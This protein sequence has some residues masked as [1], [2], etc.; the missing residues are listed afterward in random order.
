MAV[1]M[2]Q[3]T[4][5]AR[6]SPPRRE[7]Q[8][9]V[10]DAFSRDLQKSFAER[11]AVAPA[12]LPEGSSAALTICLDD[13]PFATFGVLDATY[14]WTFDGGESCHYAKDSAVMKRFL[15]FELSAALARAGKNT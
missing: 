10:L 12:K 15:T 7:D 1:A 5:A 4:D 14:Y 9:A 8:R 2:K 11:I 6:K 3:A 13:A